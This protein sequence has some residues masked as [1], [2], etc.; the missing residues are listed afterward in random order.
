VEYEKP[1]ISDYGDLVE[2]TAQTTSSGSLDADFE[3]GTPD[4]E[5][6]FS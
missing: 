6:T 1:T 3:A 2:L 5:L 4:S